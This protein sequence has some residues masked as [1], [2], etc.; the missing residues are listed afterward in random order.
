MKKSLS[1]KDIK[2]I[3]NKQIKEKIKREAFESNIE[4]YIVNNEKYLTYALLYP[5]WPKQS[6]FKHWSL[7]Y[8]I[9]DVDA[10]RKHEGSVDVCKPINVFR[11][12]KDFKKFL[13]TGE[14]RKPNEFELERLKSN[15][16]FMGHFR[17]NELESI[18]LDKYSKQ[19]LDE[20]FEN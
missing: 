6:K 20:I 8:Y 19:H 10:V 3:S 7:A 16:R 14:I 11:K 18:K 17:I 12:Y 4:V 2:K 5:Y 1:N 9:L 13:K 15:D